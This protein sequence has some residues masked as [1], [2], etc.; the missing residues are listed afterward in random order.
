MSRRRIAILGAGPIGLEAALAASESG[1][2]FTV[3]EAGPSVA[4]NV[5]SWGHVRLFTPWSMNV[6]SRMR[7]ALAEVGREPP[8]D[9]PCPTGWELVDEVLEPVASLRSIEPN[10]RLSS[11]VLEVGREGL[12]KSDEIGTGARAERPF[13]L[14]VRLPDGRERVERADVVVDCTGTY[15]NPNALGA[16]GIRA[17]GEDAASELIIRR[18]P[19][20][21]APEEG[22]ESSAWDG[23]RILLVGAGHSAQTAAR[24]LAELVDRAPDTRV[25]WVIRSRKPAFGAVEDDPLPA[26]RALVERAAELASSGSPFDVRTGRSVEAL[27]PSPDGIVVTLGGPDVDGEEVTV[28]RIVSLTGSVGDARMY[29]QL[30]VHECYATSGPM[31]LAGALLA[32]SSADCL[33]Q[34]SQGP[35]TLRN[36][37]PDF[38]ILGSKSYGRNN[39]FLI[40]VGWEQV[41]EVFSVLA[42]ESAPLETP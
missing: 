29:R 41:R 7:E 4:G 16:G 2:P 33:T 3:Y 24:D 18:I 27:E 30:Q 5:R 21:E 11:R 15:H 17:P 9:H 42:P 23:E 28:D 40:R 13:R 6:S 32:S 25:T 34:E 19:V 8:D 10:L 31:R 14:L 39:T 20:L 12:L 35:D 37:E 36:P 26:R 22:G 38:F 1:F